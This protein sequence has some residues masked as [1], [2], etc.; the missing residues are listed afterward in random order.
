MES[1]GREEKYDEVLWEATQA[2]KLQKNAKQESETNVGFTK[3]TNK[4]RKLTFLTP[5]F[6]PLIFHIRP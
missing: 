4:C 2:E 1:K 6:L 3:T 5:H